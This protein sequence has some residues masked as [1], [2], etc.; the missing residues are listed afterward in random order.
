MNRAAH[1]PYRPGVGVVLLNEH[2]Q[3]FAGRRI[4]QVGTEVWQWPQGGVDQ[5]EAPLDAAYRELQE[6]TGLRREDVVLVDELSGE[7]AYDLPPDL[8]NPPRWA[9]RFRGQQQRWYVMRLTAGDSAIDLA[10]HH[11][12]FDAHRWVAI[13]EAVAG[14]VPFKRRLYENVAHAVRRLATGQPTEHNLPTT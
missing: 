5:G 13:D 1:D 2:G 11:P 10:T 8:P 9:E 6:E 4:R 7:F 12:E 14:A 3:T